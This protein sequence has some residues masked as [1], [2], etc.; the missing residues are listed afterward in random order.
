[1]I[2]CYLFLYLTGEGYTEQGCIHGYLSRVRLGRGS[3]ESLQALK[4]QNT[5]ILGIFLA[6]FE[7]L[8]G[9]LMLLYVRYF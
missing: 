3:T 5:G 4:Q 8:V 2:D 7:T 6:I 9:A 1:M